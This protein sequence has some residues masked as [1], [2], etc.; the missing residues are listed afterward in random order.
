M[1][2]TTTKIEASEKDGRRVQGIGDDDGGGSGLIIGLVDC[3]RQWSVEFL[4]IGLLTVTLSRL[5]LFAVL[6]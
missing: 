4:A 1:N 2:T 3:K 6:F 5:Y